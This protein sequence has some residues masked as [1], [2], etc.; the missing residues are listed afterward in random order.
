MK[1]IFISWSKKTS[2]EF[3]KIVKYTIEKLAADV[4]VFM[5]EEDIQAGE[6]VQEKIIS[7]IEECD[8][9]IL[10]F[11]NENKKSPW[12]LF[13]AGYAS[14]MHKIVIP[15]LF[16]NDSMWHSWIDNPMN[17]AREINIYESDLI[18]EF[19]EI[20]SLNKTSKIK[21]V[22][23]QFKQDIEVCREQ[24]REVDIQCED[25][26]EK[27][28]AIDKFNITSPF[29]IERTVYFLSGFETFE[30]WKVIIQ[31]FLYTGKY[32]W[33]YG[34]KNMKLF[35]G[36]FNELFQYLDEK[37]VLPNMDGIDFKIMFLN[38]ESEE[39]NYA[40]KDQDIFKLEL[41]TTILRAKRTI[42]SNKSVQKCCRMYSN[43]RDEIIIRIDN[44]IVY[45]KPHFDI[46]GNPNIMT[47][48]AFEVF[49]AFSEKGKR[50][51]QK[52]MEVWNNAIDM[53]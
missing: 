48:S 49:S 51:I 21:N 26:V 11:T 38:P 45:C 43:K 53:F 39:V 29:C 35:G 37:A 31:S 40:H 4:H 34:R 8:I 50:C 23:E 20:F 22:I 25:L 13:E 28:S 33:I 36:N 44:C 2:R 5:S 6:F 14:G 15:F 42:G 46:N 17:I 27:L 9:L 1:K 10:C 19:C 32:L 3:A 24:F 16:D 47:N 18:K 30:L 52:Y 12:L 41:E 7:N